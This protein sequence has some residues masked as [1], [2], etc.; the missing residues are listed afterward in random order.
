MFRTLLLFCIVT[1]S[2]ITNAQTINPVLDSLL[3]STLHERRAALQIT[4]MSAAIQFSDN[5]IWAKGSGLSTKNPDLLVTPDHV[6]GIASITKTLTAGIILQL[7]DEGKLSLDE[8]VKKWFPELATFNAGITIKHL[9]R[10]ESG[11]Y[12]V[13]SAPTIQQDMN[14][15]I[16]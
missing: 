16:M 3:T 4:G 14:V 7:I 6:F 1:V 8:N 11:L 9:L 10:H 15:F 12:D 5:Q 13:I 2:V